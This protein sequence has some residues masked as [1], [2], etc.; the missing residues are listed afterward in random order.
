MVTWSFNTVSDEA[1]AD[2]AGKWYWR[3][4]TAPPV[5]LTSVRLFPTLDECAAD[6]RRKGF[7][8]GAAPVRDDPVS[9]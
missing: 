8:E 5:V 9:A 6:A 2:A 1:S 7:D 4:N 3:A